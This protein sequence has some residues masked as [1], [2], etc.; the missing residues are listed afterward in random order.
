MTVFLPISFDKIA[1]FYLENEINHLYTHSGKIYSIPENLEE[2]ERQVS[3]TFFRV[4]RQFLVNRNAI[5][6]ATEHFPRKL[7]VNLKFPFNKKYHCK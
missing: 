6:D 3:S 5:R 1:L 2:L 4:N 7:K